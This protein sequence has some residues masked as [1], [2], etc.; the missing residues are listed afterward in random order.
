MKPIKE[1]WPIWGMA[2]YTMLAAYLAYL[3][4]KFWLLQDK[5]KALYENPEQIV[6]IVPF[7]EA[8]RL[9][10]TALFYNVIAYMAVSIALCFMSVIYLGIFYFKLSRRPRD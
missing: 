6:N 7:V 9:V 5:Q 8:V 10:H 2:M 1:S 4:V 3:A